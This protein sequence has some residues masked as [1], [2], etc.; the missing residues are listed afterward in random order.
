MIWP[1]SDPAELANFDP[2]T[3]ECTMNC[4][5]HSAD[6]RSWKE[7]KFQCNDC[8]TVSPNDKLIERPETEGGAK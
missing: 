6:P 5:Q 2:A 3:K 4:G 8:I 1:R 7:C